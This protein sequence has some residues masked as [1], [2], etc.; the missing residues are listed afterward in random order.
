MRPQPEFPIRT[1]S[2]EAGLSLIETLIVLVIIGLVSAMIIPNVISRPDDAR[3]T[4][5]RN[6]L[7]S[8]AAALQLYRLDNRAYP[9]TAQGLAALAERPAGDPQPSNWHPEG[10]LDGVPVDPWGNPYVYRMP[11]QSGAFDLLSLGADGQPGGEN[12][13]ADIHLRETAS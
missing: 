10:Y 2:R 13:D 3:V 1:S 9:S 12:Y 4:V 5:A 11:G 7:A 6:D 8:L